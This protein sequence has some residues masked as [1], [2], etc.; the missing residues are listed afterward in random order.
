MSGL[1]RA[2]ERAGVKSGDLEKASSYQRRAG[3]AI[4]HILVNMGALSEDQL[5]T[6]Y[7]DALK[8]PL[9][10]E[11]FMDDWQPSSL[12]YEPDRSSQGACK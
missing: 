2:I 5:P 12:G 8:E 9:L 11:A 3:G 7:S 4:E 10:D 6:L 1:R